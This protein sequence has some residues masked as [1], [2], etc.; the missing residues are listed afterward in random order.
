VESSIF[1]LSI[2]G[3]PKLIRQHHTHQFQFLLFATPDQPA[4]V[5]ESSQD[6]S[7]LC[8]E[9]HHVQGA[10][11]SRRIKTGKQAGKALV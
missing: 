3:R 2:D 9:Q 11:H 5:Q 8:H 6:G 10:L 4:C 1:S 7:L